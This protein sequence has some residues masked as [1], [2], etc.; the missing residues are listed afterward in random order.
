M[1]GNLQPE[2]DGLVYRNTVDNGT[3]E[4]KVTRLSA[5]SGQFTVTVRGSEEVL[6]SEEV[7]L[8]YQAMFG[9]DVADV[10]E[11]QNRAITVI[12][13]WIEQRTERS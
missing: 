13:Q 9:P 6:L 2:S 12:D 4:V 7:G 11:W 5:Y 10:A 8:A 1:T 3:F